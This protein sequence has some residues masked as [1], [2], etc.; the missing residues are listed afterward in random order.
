MLG[1]TLGKVTNGVIRAPLHYVDDESWQTQTKEHVR[2]RMSMPFFYRMAPQAKLRPCP[3]LYQN[4]DDDGR[5]PPL[6]THEFMEQV[7][8]PQ[9]PWRKTRCH[10]Y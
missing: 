9:R 3:P 4:D 1:E 2:T 8:F 6:T 5:P 10:D 7:V